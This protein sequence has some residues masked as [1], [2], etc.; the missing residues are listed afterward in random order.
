[1]SVTISTDIGFNYYY[2]HN[3]DE[4][5]N[6]LRAT[7]AVSPKFPLAHLRLG[8]AYQQK[9]MYSEA[10]EEFNKT[11]AASPGWVVTIAGMTEQNAKL[12]IKHTLFDM[13]TTRMGLAI[14]AIA[15]QFDHY[16]QMVEYLRINN[17]VAPASR[18]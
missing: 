15:H 5:I 6:Q 2:R 13:I 3:Y 9:K 14:V 1:L 7:L 18:Q 17:I 11:D 16:W 10:I 12:P 8:R 4:A